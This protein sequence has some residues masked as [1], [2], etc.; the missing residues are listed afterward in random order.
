MSERKTWTPGDVVDVA[1][2]PALLRNYLEQR[3]VRAYLHKAAAHTPV[4][5]AY[6]IG[7]GFGRLTPVLSEVAADVVGFER[8]ASLVAAARALLPDLRFEQV[9]T[10]EHLPAE[11]LSA[12]FIL[13]FTVLQ[14]MTD[15][16]SRAVIGEIQRLLA[17][18]GHLLVVEETNPRLEAGDAARAD[19][20]YTRGR[21]VA[22]YVDALKPL[23]LVATSPRR[24]EPDYPRKDVG[25]YMFF[26]RS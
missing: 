7:S 10:L 24:I 9:P 2:P 8:E 17:P 14:H 16:S 15:A 19:L 6:D 23:E 1:G 26:R 4:H 21:P 22:W 20:G 25:T 12:E 11:P 13:T 3:D 18:A 5:R